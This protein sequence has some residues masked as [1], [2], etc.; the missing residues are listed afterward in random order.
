MNLILNVD[1]YKTATKTVSAPSQPPTRKEKIAEAVDIFTTALFPPTAVAKAL[2]GNQTIGPETPTSIDIA[3]E[4]VMIDRAGFTIFKDKDVLRSNESAKE[5]RWYNTKTGRS[6]SIVDKEGRPLLPEF[7]DGKPVDISIINPTSLGRWQSSF[8]DYL[9]KNL[10]EDIKENSPNIKSIFDNVGV[11]RPNDIDKL[12]EIGLRGLANELGIDV[13]EYSTK[14]TYQEAQ[15]GKVPELLRD[16]LA[17]GLITYL[18]DSKG[19]EDYN[20]IK[21]DVPEV[22]ENLI[23][24]EHQNL[25]KQ[26]K[27]NIQK[28][29]LIQKVNHLL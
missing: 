7:S 19:Y 3:G 10:I 29:K 23:D 26:N 1:K 22:E 6:T 2:T 5:P 21:H 12:D 17:A 24:F 28:L 14:P 13:R 20:I 11:T 25:L 18:S 9:N 8:N 4:W 27:Q 15:A 16:E